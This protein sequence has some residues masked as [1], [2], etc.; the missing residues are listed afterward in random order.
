MQGWRAKLKQCGER[1][2]LPLVV[3]NRIKWVPSTCENKSRHCEAF[4]GRFT[5]KI[6]SI[7]TEESLLK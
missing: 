5:R 6:A 1:V 7:N 4:P 3:M 2:C